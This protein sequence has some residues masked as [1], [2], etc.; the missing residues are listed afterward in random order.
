M[1]PMSPG[2][3]E[4]DRVARLRRR[5]F[6]LEGVTLGWNVVGIVVLAFAAVAAHRSRWPG[7]GSTR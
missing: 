1:E 7:S 5:G 3:A 6:V 2:G 4:P